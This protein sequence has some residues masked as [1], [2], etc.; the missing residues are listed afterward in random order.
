[1]RLEQL[2]YLK[3]IHEYSSM[4]KASTALFVSQQSISSAIKSLENEL[5][6]KLITRTNKGSYLTDAGKELVHAT[7]IFYKTCLNIREKYCDYNSEPLSFNIAAEISL[8]KYYEAIILYFNSVE[9][10]P[11]INFI[12][13]ERSS[14][15]DIL[16]TDPTAVVLMGCTEKQLNSIVKEYKCDIIWCSNLVLCVSEKNPLAKYST[17]SLKSLNHKTILFSAINNDTSVILEAI[18]PYDLKT[19][20][21]YKFNASFNIRHK[22]IEND[23]VVMLLPNI[24]TPSMIQVPFTKIHLKEK[25]PIYLCCITKQNRYIEEICNALKTSDTP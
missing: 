3:A 16:D 6:T 17:L 10:N 19:T 14:L 4:N 11:D 22:L 20:N 9:K 15:L 7:E 13:K 21:S 1:M 5:G 12:P 25:I 24:F 8:M 23:N 18:E 2:N